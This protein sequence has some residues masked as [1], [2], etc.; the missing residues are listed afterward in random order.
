[1]AFLLYFL[2]KYQR[3][4]KLLFH[5]TRKVYPDINI[6]NLSKIKDETPYL[7]ACLKETLR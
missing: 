4:Q 7:Q 5:E 3:T 1:M 6:Q 2:S